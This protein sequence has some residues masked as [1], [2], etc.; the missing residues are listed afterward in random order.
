MKK[1]LDWSDQQIK[2]NREWL[3]KD[4]QLT[5][6][7]G[8]IATNGPNWR[9]VLQQGMEPGGDMGGMGG[10]MPMGDLGGFPGEGG[11]LPEFGGEADVPGE[12]P[13]EGGGGEGLPA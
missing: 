9:E 3:K 2:Q 6:E 12:L 8:Q 1:Y 5:W 11:A 13:P 4:A 10:G 7:I